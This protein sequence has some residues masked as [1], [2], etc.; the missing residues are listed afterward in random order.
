MSVRKQRRA[1]AHKARKVARKLGFPVPPP[2][3]SPAPAPQQPE[4]IEPSVEPPE[5]FPEPGYPFPSLKEIS[6]AKLIANRLNAQK[7]TGAKSETTRAISAQNHT[8][9]GLA[10]HRNGNFKLLTSEDPEA[11]A[12]LKQEHAPDTE[13]ESILVNTMVE[14]HWLSQRAQRMQ[15][16]CTDPDSG[17]VTDE[18]KFSLYLRYQTTHTRAFH[19]SLNDLLKLRAERRKAEIGLEAQ[20]IQTE[21]H[22]MKKNSHYWDVLKKDCEATNQMATNALQNLK[23]QEQHPGFEAKYEAELAQRGL[24]KNFAESASEVA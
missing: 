21:K 8:L 19:K 24:K 2:S 22:E 10:R 20:R 16:T 9:H 3:T 15:D 23:A 5:A 11:F 13:T 18:K 17:A 4:T 1:E 14:C 12:A 6:P 7:S